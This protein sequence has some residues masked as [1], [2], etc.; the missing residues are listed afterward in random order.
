MNTFTHQAFEFRMRPT[1][2]QEAAL[3]HVLIGSRLLY[4]Q[5]LEELIKHYEATGKHLN[6]SRAR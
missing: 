3:M 5:C 1:P 2:S 4:N 6:L